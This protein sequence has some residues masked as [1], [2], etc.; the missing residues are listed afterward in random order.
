MEAARVKEIEDLIINHRG[1]AQKER[2]KSKK[3]I[4]DFTP[5]EIREISNG[6][7]DE[8]GI[9]E[10]PKYNVTF[11]AYNSVSKMEIL[12]FI[13]Y[14][15]RFSDSL[16]RS[17]KGCG[18]NFGEKQHYRFD[19]SGYEGITG[20]NTL[21]NQ[22]ILNKFAYLGIYDY[23]HF[24]CLDFYKG[25]VSLYMKY[26]DDDS[27]GGGFKVDLSNKPTTEIIYTIFMYTVFT[28]RP[29]RRTI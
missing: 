9:R 12:D 22:M 28:D 29:T 15:L 1:I 26:W 20:W 3:T 11:N 21:H 25:C 23:T 4:L 6:N 16:I 14:K 17:L 24:L 2:N 8:K 19:M 7:L 13:R 10:V 18:I 5:E 27:A